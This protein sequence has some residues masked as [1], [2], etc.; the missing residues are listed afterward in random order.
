V[1]EAWR[2]NP[3]LGFPTS[4]PYY[5]AD[6]MHLDFEHGGMHADKDDVPALLAGGSLVPRISHSEGD[7]LIGDVD[8]VREHIIRQQNGVAWWV[9][10]DA[11][12][13]WIPDIDTWTCLGGD[14]AV[15]EGLDNLP[16]WGPAALDLGPPA[17]CP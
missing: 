5:G 13:H 15:A 1:L 17:E 10:A 11:V 8:E 9:D 7:F 14:D 4:N 16:G 6:G 12:R 2:A 3:E